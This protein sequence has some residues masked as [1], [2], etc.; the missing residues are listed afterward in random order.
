MKLDLAYGAVL[1]GPEWIALEYARALREDEKTSLINRSWTTA[2]FG[3]AQGSPYTHIDNENLP[4]TKARTA[5]LKHLASSNK[6]AMR[7]RIL[8]IPILYCFYSSRNWKDE[9]EEDY[10]IIKS[11]V[12]DSD[13]YN[14][15]EKK[16][17]K[18]QKDELLAAFR[19]HLDKKHL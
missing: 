4:W 14:A 1:T 11:T 13:L 18:Q 19:T 10:E 17:L 9:N 3:D 8:E 5:R 6:K 16:F 7:F 12:I 15:E 2:Y